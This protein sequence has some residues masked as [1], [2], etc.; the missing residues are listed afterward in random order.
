MQEDPQ[1]H[2]LK[3][4]LYS[5]RNDSIVYAPQPFYPTTLSLCIN[6]LW[7][8]SFTLT[9][10]SAL[11]G[12]LAKGWVAKYTP[13]SRTERCQDA[14][15][16]HLRYVRARQWHLGGIITGLPIL[17][18][19]ALLLF[20]LGL[21]LFTHD[22]NPGIG[23]TILVLI[24]FTLLLYVTSTI[25]PIFS[26]AAPLHTPISDLISSA[27]EK[28]RTHGR[29]RDAKVIPR[30]QSIV[31][32]LKN[33]QGQPTQI[34]IKANILAWIFANSKDDKTLKEAV[35]AMA[36]TT[37]YS[38]GA[39]RDAFQKNGADEYFCQKF[40]HCFESTPSNV[41]LREAYLYALLRVVQP[42][43]TSLD[44]SRFAALL[45]PKQPLHRWD[46]SSERCLWALA[47][48]VRTHIRAN[49]DKDDDY[50]DETWQQTRDNLVSIAKAG[51]TPYVRKILA[52][53]AMRG[54][55]GKMMNL[56]RLC[57]LVLS[58]RLNMGED[59]LYEQVILPIKISTADV[60]KIIRT[61]QAAGS[62]GTDP[63]IVQVNVD[64]LK[65]VLENLVILLKDDD[66]VI[67][68][69]VSQGL[70]TLTGHCRFLGLIYLMSLR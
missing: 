42:T 4:I 56:K 27:A 24:V 2:L 10:I 16:R 26:P 29:P 53:A 32:F 61:P 47:F 28:G 68:N 59:P 45:N 38:A 23:F 25:L 55:A 1:E 67:R 7:F 35:K 12:V 64:V 58:R 49:Q 46:G 40:V 18:Q 48:S 33:V 19:L 65:D 63:A 34:Q 9:L 21:V 8:V 41:C 60:R 30:W 37:R 22:G 36:G 66:H 31:S 44:N 51:S 3:E 43:D 20:L 6:F 62:K 14:C 54:L 15:D 70:I 13:T 50:D 11:G 52:E 57:G 39:L 69:S 5:I 17:I